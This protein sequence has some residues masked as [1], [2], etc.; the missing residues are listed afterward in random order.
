MPFKYRLLGKVTDLFPNCGGV[1]VGMSHQPDLP[2][3]PDQAEDRS[4]QGS[5][6]GTVGTDNAY[7]LAGDNL[8][9][10]PFKNILSIQGYM[11]ILDS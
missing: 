10:D 11:Q 9:A 5:F 1:G 2:L 4:E 8:E 3:E 6:T 7:R